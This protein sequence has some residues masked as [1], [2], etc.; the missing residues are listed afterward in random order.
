[1]TI[2]IDFETT[3]LLDNSLIPLD[4]QPRAIEIC[5][6]KIDDTTFKSIDKFHTFINP[7]IPIPEKITSIT[8]IKDEDVED[9]PSFAAIY[10]D[11]CEFFLGERTM[12]AQNLGFD[13]DI[14]L[15]E[16]RR[17][18]KEIQFP[19]PFQHECTVELTTHLKGYR[20]KLGDLYEQLFG[21]KFP[22]AHKAEVDT[23]AL[24]RCYVA[25]RERGIIQ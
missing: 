6:I 14:L 10:N 16:L 11:L 24:V 9:A 7:G 22:D 21:E 3:G 4:K 8:G 1:M 12:V 19:W 5:C 15:H 23:E 25:C 17:I 13:R 20:L 18:G 2:C